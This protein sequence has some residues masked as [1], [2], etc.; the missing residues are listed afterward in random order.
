MI[1]AETLRVRIDEIIADME[2]QFGALAPTY[3]ELVAESLAGSK[4]AYRQLQAFGR[5]AMAPLIDYYGVA[6]GALAAEWYDINRELAKVGGQWSGAVVQDPNIDTGPLVGGVLKDYVTFE[7]IVSGLQSGMD[8]RV[9]Q[10]AQG[11]IMDSTLRD[12]NA[13]GWGREAS[14]G[15][16]SYC[17]MLAGRGNVYRT[18]HTATF[19]PHEHCRC[20]AIPAWGG[21][22]TALRSREDTL[23]TRR[24]L[25]DD[26][27]ARQNKQ[28]RNWISQNQES[29]GLI[30]S[31]GSAVL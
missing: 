11:T 23:A 20:H 4:T 2:R 21:D 14:A 28:A 7:S 5:Q 10:A 13:T 12:P 24:T 31:Q 17:A 15:C 29:L 25:T 3:E 8:L 18:Q 30:Q 1:L 27:R 9:R 6:T 19:M 26:Q 22:A 16:C